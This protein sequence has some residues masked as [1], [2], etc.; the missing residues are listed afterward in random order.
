MQPVT[1]NRISYGP[2]DVAAR[3]EQ[4]K[5]LYEMGIHDPKEL[6]QRLGCY[7]SETE[8]FINRYEFERVD[9]KT[10]ADLSKYA[11]NEANEAN[12]A[13]DCTAEEDLSK[14]AKE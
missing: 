14:Y 12:A 1:S 8:C 2:E 9:L 6:T 7:K 5:L 10:E 11:S 3:Y 4:F 13:I